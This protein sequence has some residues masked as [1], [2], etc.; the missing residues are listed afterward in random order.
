MSSTKISQ[1]R[2]DIPKHTINV[3]NIKN[4]TFYM[5]E[6]TPCAPQSVT[7]GEIVAVCCKSNTSYVLINFVVKY[8]VL[9]VTAF[10][11]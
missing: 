2:F 9:I 6:N 1:F 10:G 4:L 7:F 5:T 8:G 3:S 11:T